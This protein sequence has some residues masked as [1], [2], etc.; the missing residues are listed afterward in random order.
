M[1][2]FGVVANIKNVHNNLF[3][4]NILS[5]MVKLVVDIISDILFVCL[6]QRPYSSLRY[7]IRVSLC[8]RIQ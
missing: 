6:I 5:I 8:N 1:I 7:Q 3:P 2:V 4:L